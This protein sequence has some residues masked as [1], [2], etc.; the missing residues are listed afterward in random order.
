[1]KSISLSHPVIWGR[2][3]LLWAWLRNNAMMIVI[4]AIVLFL[5]LVPVTRLI[6]TS[7]QIGHPAFPE[8]WSTDNY[9]SAFTTPDFYGTLGRTFWIAGLG[10]FISLTFAVLLAWLVERTDMPLRN[11]GWAMILIPMAVPN[12]L[13]AMGWTLLLSPMP[14]P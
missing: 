6:I 4:T 7:L 14:E 12:I 13:F 8:G 10:T 5:V 3:L 1:M 2:A 11:L 9:V